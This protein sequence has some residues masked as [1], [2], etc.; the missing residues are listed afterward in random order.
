MIEDRA[1]ILA[2]KSK[3]AKNEADLMKARTRQI[4]ITKILGRQDQDIAILTTKARRDLGEYNQMSKQYIR[5]FMYAFENGDLDKLPR[6]PFAPPLEQVEQAINRRKATLIEKV[7][8]D[9]RIKKLEFINSQDKVSKKVSYKTRTP[10][11]DW[12]T[13]I[14][15]LLSPLQ[16]TG[17]EEE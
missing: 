8:A 16:Q 2:L 7:Q 14:L 11:S 3:T 17:I 9:D 15:T 5:S 1:A 13:Y 6:H 10:L 12:P 4:D